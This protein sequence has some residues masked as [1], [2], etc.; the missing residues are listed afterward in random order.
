MPAMRR[1]A[2]RI[3]QSTMGRGVVLQVQPLCPCILGVSAG[4]SLDM[5]TGQ[6]GPDG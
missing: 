2:V 1:N 3:Y 4:V 5:E 6:W